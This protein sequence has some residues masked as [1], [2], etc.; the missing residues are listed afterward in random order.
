M[1]WIFHFIFSLTMTIKNPNLKSWWPTQVINTRLPACVKHVSSQTSKLTDRLPPH[2]VILSCRRRWF[3]KGQHLLRAG[4]RPLRTG[5]DCPCRGKMLRLSLNKFIYPEEGRWLSYCCHWPNKPACFMN[6]A[7][8]HC[9]WRFLL[10]KRVFSFHYQNM[11]VQEGI[12][13]CVKIK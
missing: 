8:P 4:H 13:K 1:S 3:D 5:V 10:F 9:C 2:Y 12:L 7:G 11:L 6:D